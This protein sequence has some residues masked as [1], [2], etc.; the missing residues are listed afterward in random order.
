VRA[1]DPRRQVERCTPSR[2]IEAWFYQAK[3]I[4]GAF[5]KNL[6]D[7]LEYETQYGGWATQTWDDVIRHAMLALPFGV[8]GMADW[9]T[10]VKDQINFRNLSWRCLILITAGTSTAQ[11]KSLSRFNNAL[12]R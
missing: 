10:P 2:Q 7:G 3:E 4:A 9:L 6:F 11:P 12:A 8:S 1:A 5:K